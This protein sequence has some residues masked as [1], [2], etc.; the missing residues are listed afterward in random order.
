MH[1]LE[2]RALLLLVAGVS[3]LFGWI[4]WPFSGAILWAIVLATLFSPLYQRLLASM[5]RWP[6]SAA[7][8]TVLIIVVMVI[9]PLAFVTSL[10]LQEAADVYAA[11][12][13]GELTIGGG[14]QQARDA[15]PDWVASLLDRLRTLDLAG[16]RERLSTLLMETGRFLAGQA[17]NLGQGT[18]NS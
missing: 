15:L 11:F 9:L 7:L 10:L 17:V 13:S 16:L 18:I 12:Q 4:L 14:L 8:L 2:D 1:D 3:L 5:P 6:N